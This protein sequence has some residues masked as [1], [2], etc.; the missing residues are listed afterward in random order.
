MSSELDTTPKIA[1]RVDPVYPPIAA[2][3]KI[4]ALVIVSALVDEKG[5]VIDAKVLRGAASKLGFDEAS[6]AAIRKF[7][8]TPATKDGKKVK[9]WYSVPFIFGKQK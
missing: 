6:L 9:T 4:S 2:R 3:Q 8:F 1:R 7:T 5:K